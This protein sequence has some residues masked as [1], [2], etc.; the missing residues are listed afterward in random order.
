MPMAHILHLPK[1]SNPL[2]GAG[3]FTRRRIMRA[4]SERK[5]YRYVKPAITQTADGWLITSPCCS[6]NVDPDGGVIDI[7]R[8]ICRAEEW[9]LMT[10]DAARTGW[11]EHATEARLDLLLQILCEDKERVFWP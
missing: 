4:L 6:R 3:E 2:V 9:T 5:R 11:I 10:R 8:L 7:A 1:P